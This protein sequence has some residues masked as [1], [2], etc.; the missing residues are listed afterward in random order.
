LGLQ[1]LL[2]PARLDRIRRASR[3]MVRSGSPVLT[4][5]DTL[6]N[7][8]DAVF[9]EIACAADGSACAMPL[10]AVDSASWPVQT[11]FVAKLVEHAS[12]TPAFGE[13]GA[14][15]ALQLRRLRAKLT[16]VSDPVRNSV[17]G[18]FLA[19]T[20]TAITKALGEAAPQ[21]TA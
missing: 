19:S 18:E 8:T 7:I 5:A 12:Y 20:A 21:A 14:A 10:L 9:G 1:V 4:V 17:H 11:Y 3:L 16:N 2:E 6:G 13:V 15:A